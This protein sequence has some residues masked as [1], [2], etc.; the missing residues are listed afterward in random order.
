MSI[1]FQRGVQYSTISFSLTK[2]W[3]AAVDKGKVFGAL[4]TDLLK[5]FDSLNLEPFIAKLNTY[6][7][8][9]FICFEISS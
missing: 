7:W 3:K 4:L 8:V 5:A 6:V 2:K 9:Y 1:W